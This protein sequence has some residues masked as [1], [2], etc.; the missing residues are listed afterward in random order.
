[1]WKK[2]PAPRHTENPGVRSP[3]YPYPPYGYAGGRGGGGGGAATKQESDGGSEKMP[4]ILAISETTTEVDSCL[5]APDPEILTNHS[6]AAPL[7]RFTAIV[8]RIHRQGG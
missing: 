5:P 1:M 4:C 3:P 2:R 8:S 6:E 7:A